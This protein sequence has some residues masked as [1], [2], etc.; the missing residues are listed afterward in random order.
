MP[1]AMRR[2]RTEVELL[3]AAEHVDYEV[4]MMEEMAPLQGGS[5]PADPVTD[6][7]YLESFVIHVRNLIYFLNP[8]GK[9][10][11]REDDILALD[12]T[13]GASNWKNSRP[14]IWQR[15]DDAYTRVNKLAA[16]LT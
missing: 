7:A 16:H 6:N 5:S 14:E 8:E 4:W 13:G 9:I 15:L 2:E 1:Q 10:K 11:P 12:F 3:K